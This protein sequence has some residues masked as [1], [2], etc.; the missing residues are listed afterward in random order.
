MTPGSTSPGREPMMRP[1]N[2]VMPIV[3]SKLL[4]CLMAQME[5]PLP[6]WQLMMFSSFQSLPIILAAFSA[7]NLWLVPWKP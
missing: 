4:P 3:V 5:A 1:S 6:R 2:G 7:T